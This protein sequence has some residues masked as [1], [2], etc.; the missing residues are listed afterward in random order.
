[1]KK[2]LILIGL[3]SLTSLSFSQESRRGLNVSLKSGVTLANMYG[4]DVEKE[5]FLNGDNAE[6]FYAN[7]PASSVFKAGANVGLKVDYR[8][9]RFFSLGIGAS[10]IQK[11]AKINANKHWNSS[12]QL[13]E[14]VDGKV[15]WHQNF[16][17]IELPLTIYIPIKQN[18][19][20]FQAGVF[21]GFLANSEERGEVSF[22]DQNYEYTTY[23]FANKN[24]L[25][26]SLSGG[27]IYSLPS[28]YGKI[29]AEMAWTRS[30]LGSIGRDMIPNPQSYY[31][32]TLSF[33]IGYMYTFNFSK[34]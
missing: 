23:R 19:L 13:Y 11:G 17:T 21:G 34:K 20:Y 10:Y 8:F 9:G 5:T 14:D 3:L 7:N 24:E 32:Q 16:W 26:Y 12:S 27:Y 30:F 22:A 1:M 25:G 33:N 31:N 2:V 29:F 18:D 15:L 4:K 6:E 28:N